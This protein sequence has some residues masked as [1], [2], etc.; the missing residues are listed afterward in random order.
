MENVL[1]YYEFS[2][3]KKDTSTTFQGNEIAY[4]TL[5]DTHFLIFEKAGHQYNLYVAKYNNRKEIGIVAPQLI[6]TLVINYSKS[7]PAHRKAIKQ[8]LY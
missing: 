5:N 8:Y 3:F 7:E 6:E 1:K 2:E 4:T